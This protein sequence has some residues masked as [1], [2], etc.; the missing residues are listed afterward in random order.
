MR[1]G[2]WAIATGVVFCAGIGFSPALALG[3]VAKLLP[4]DGALEDYFGHVVAVSGNIAVVGMQYDDDQGENSGSAYVFGLNGGEWV[5][6]AKLLPADGEASDKFGVSVDIDGTTIVVGAEEDDDSAVN[7]GSAYVFQFDGT[8]W[9]QQAKLLAPDGN[10]DTLFGHSVALSGETVLIGTS[11]HERRDEY[12][13]SAYVFRFDG[14]SW[15]PEAKLAASDGADADLYGITVDLDGDTAVISAPYDDVVDR[16]SGSAYVFHYDGADWV[17]QQKV[18]PADGAKLDSFG[19]AVAVSGN[20]LLVGAPKVGEDDYSGSD[21]GAAYVFQFDGTSWVEQAKLLAW[22]DSPYDWFGWAVAL[23]GD[24]AII[25]APGDREPFSEHNTGS[26]HVF[27]F[28]G[29]NW[30]DERKLIASDRAAWDRFG[31]AVALSGDTAVVGALRDDD[32]GINSGSAYV[33]DVTA[34]PGDLNADLHVDIADLA[35]L[36]GHYD[37]PAGAIY[38]DGDLDG[39]GDVDLADLAG[40]LQHY[41]DDCE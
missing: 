27:R 6:Q 29:E 15:V 35:Q 32:H 16:D 19:A 8:N 25:A 2:I 34:C 40:L 17:E 26:A 11:G 33:F 36:L 41:G 24:T 4:A 3:E 13:G 20:T 39:D 9:V 7:A 5:Q 22:D 31:W 18:T 30:I 37:T 14:S 23:D 1:R 38:S 21:W 28:N 10:A 12:T